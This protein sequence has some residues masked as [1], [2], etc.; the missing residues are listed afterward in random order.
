MD[1]R[2]L[3]P[4]KE[5]FAELDVDLSTLNEQ[6]AKTPELQP[7]RDLMNNLLDLHATL[8]DWDH[9]A[10]PLRAAQADL[11]KALESP[12]FDSIRHEDE[13]MDYEDES[14]PAEE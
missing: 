4:A 13:F 6:A 10:S 7:L 8:E 12:I 14:A 1:D 11:A 9:L 5:V 3:I 2:G